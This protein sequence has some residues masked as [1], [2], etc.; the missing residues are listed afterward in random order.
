LD[1]K[2]WGRLGAILNSQT[3]VVLANPAESQHLLLTL[4]TSHILPLSGPSKAGGLGF[5]AEEANGGV[6]VFAMPKSYSLITEPMFRGLTVANTNGISGV[7]SRE[8]P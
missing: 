7:K 1:L 2:I 4:S 8:T 6:S 5:S 3:K